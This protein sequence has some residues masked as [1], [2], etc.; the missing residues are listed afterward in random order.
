[1]KVSDKF[2]KVEKPEDINP[3]E[4]N[5]YCAELYRDSDNEKRIHDLELEEEKSL[6]QYSK[7]QTLR[8][9][10]HIFSSGAKANYRYNKQV[11]KDHYKSLRE[12]LEK[13]DRP[14][15]V[16][17][18]VNKLKKLSGNEEF[19]KLRAQFTKKV[20]PGMTKDTITAMERTVETIC[21]KLEN[22]LIVNP[23]KFKLEIKSARLDACEAGA[24]TN[25]QKIL[26]SMDD[27]LYNQK[28]DYIHNLANQYLKD[29]KLVDHAGNEVHVANQLIHEV[30][31]DYH[32]IPPKDMYAKYRN[33]DLP[34][35]WGFE[36]FPAFKAALDKHFNSPEGVTNFVEIL[37]NDHLAN[38]PDAPPKGKKFS[39]IPKKNET[40]DEYENEEMDKITAIAEKLEITTESIITMSSD[41][42]EFEYREDYVSVIQ[43]AVR[44]K[45]SQDGMLNHDPLVATRVETITTPARR[46]GIMKDN[47]G[48]ILKDE[49]NRPR[50]HMIE[51]TSKSTEYKDTIIESSGGWYLAKKAENKSDLATKVLDVSKFRGF[52]INGRKIEEFLHKQ[53]KEPLDAGISFD[54]AVRTVIETNREKGT[55]F[56]PPDIEKELVLMSDQ[57]KNISPKISQKTIESASIEDIKKL[58]EVS[59]RLMNDKGHDS[60]LN[61]VQRID[62][63]GFN[64]ALQFSD[65]TNANILN[66]W[67][68]EN[69]E[70]LVHV[71]AKAQGNRMFRED[72]LLTTLKNKGA[73]F[74]IRDNNGKTALMYCKDNSI[75]AKKLMA[76]GAEEPPAPKKRAS[77]KEKDTT[78]DTKQERIKI[79]DLLK[80]DT[81][82]SKDYSQLVEQ[83]KKARNIG[84]KVKIIV[85]G[86]GDSLTKRETRAVR[87]LMQDPKGIQSILNEKGTVEKALHEAKAPSIFSRMKKNN[88]SM[89]H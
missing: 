30:S 34:P 23:E 17:L 56:D 50:F 64:K 37:A 83:I 24:L 27:S 70:S 21:Y 2:K 66:D 16:N 4:L 88:T 51:A 86:G 20:S 58:T 57:A 76:A 87:K 81:S 12:E 41:D 59:Q 65:K 63:P 85:T 33:L 49:K 77:H 55:S 46:G 3:D 54:N 82:T 80:Q 26:Y 72:A 67:R 47:E 28:Y 45:L 39:A 61:M 35:E 52:T 5:S 43:N 68:G 40:T 74:N 25:L 36:K 38:L 48:K 32:V 31:R 78:N 60:L 1:M 10:T 8:K 15:R 9:M 69:G 75:M 7:S 79:E 53:L 18:L 62:I 22:N 44:H 84:T 71:A 13:D 19:E 14:R 11:I 29:H 73:D 89:V 42:T 6:K